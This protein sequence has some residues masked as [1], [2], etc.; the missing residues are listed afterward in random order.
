LRRKQKTEL[1][2]LPARRGTAAIVE[3]GIVFGGVCL[4]VC[5][6]RISKTTG[7]KWF[8]FDRN[9]CYNNARSDLQL[10][11]IDPEMDMGWAIHGLGWVE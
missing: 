11:T 2:F 1:A 4:S 5:M 10:L 9:M 7:R 6:H 8:G 3:A